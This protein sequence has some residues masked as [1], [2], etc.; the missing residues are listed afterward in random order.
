M[1]P[2]ATFRA[3]AGIAIINQHGQVLAFERHDVPGAWQLP[4]GGI[5]LGETAQQA[6]VRELR[7]ETGLTT[8]AVEIVGEYPDWLTYE[9]P[10][11]LQ[12]AHLGLGQTQR[13]FFFRLHNPAAVIDVRTEHPEFQDYAWLEWSDLIAR[14]AEFRRATYTKL[15]AHVS[16]VYPAGS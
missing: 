16:A 10:K 7:E 3:N 2:S 9:L 13:W 14:T 8:A 5:D 4:Q 15:A 6:A 12:S 11:A 1:K